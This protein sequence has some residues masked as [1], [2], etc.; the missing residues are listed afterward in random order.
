MSE[1]RITE[2]RCREAI[3]S[4]AR[5]MVETDVLTSSGY[6]GRG[7]SPCGT[8]VGS[9][10]AHVLR[11]GGE[12]LKGLGVRDAVRNVK[13]IIAPA[14]VG[15]AVTRQE[16][17]DEKMVD[18]DGTD[19]K[20]RLGANA[21]YSVSV[22]VARAAAHAVGLPLYRYLE[23]Q[24]R[25]TLPIPLFNVVNGGLYGERRIEMQEFMLLPTDADSYST[26]LNMGMEVF[27]E[28]ENTIRRNFG[29]NAL[30][31]GHS[32]GYAAPVSDPEVVIEM[33][34]EAT[35][36][37]GF[38]GRFEVALDCAANEFY[39]QEQDTYNF[40]G[41]DTS[42][43]EMIHYLVALSKKYPI[44]L[45]ED[46][47][48]DGDY[49]GFAIATRMLRPLPLIAGDDLFATN[50]RRL[51]VGYQAESAQALIFKPNMVGTVTEAI[52]TARWAEEHSLVLIPSIRSGGGVDD[53]IPDFSVALGAPLMK[54]GAPR[55][56]ERIAC[57]NRLLQIEEELGGIAQ[58]PSLAKLKQQYAWG[59]PQAIDSEE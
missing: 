1:I 43:D 38:E 7:S 16:A 17:I 6:K 15:E 23:T 29:A 40:L 31:M 55:S 53:P 12:R 46:P 50:I 24:E 33:I 37:A 18:L 9:G 8:S 51:E 57:H 41:R 14:L 26:A 47:L 35:V 56:G 42:R 54:S 5:P 45:I 58:F 20:T 2:I 30:R 3:D 59:W 4:K 28:L 36:E 52:Q 21:I 44:F 22:A 19:R 32:A 13:E 10:E 48:H 49:E 34:L 25:C 27:Y 39:D 11:D